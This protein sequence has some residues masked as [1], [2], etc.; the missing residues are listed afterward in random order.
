VTD[1][2]ALIRRLDAAGT[3]SADA[4]EG[5]LAG[6]QVPLVEPDT[7]TFVYRGAA[8][9]VHLQHWG[10]GLPADL[11]FERLAASDL[12]YLVLDVPPG[13][14][15]EYKIEVVDQGGTRVIQDPLNPRTAHNPFGANSVCQAYGY[16]VP[17]WAEPDPDAPQGTLSDVVVTSA[18][19]GRPATTTLYLPAGFDADPARRFPLLV[20]HDGPDYLRYAALKTVLDNLIHS[21]LVPPVVAALS[22][23]GQ[24]L[25]EY[26]DD[27]RHARFLT[28]ELVPKFEADL[29][30]VGDPG[31][32]CLM[33]ASFG[34]VASLAA[35]RRYPGFYG[36]LLL[37]SGSFA[38][39]SNGCSQRRG[40]VWQPVK[41]FVDAYTDAPE[42]VSERVFVSC[43][44]YESLICENRALVPKLQRAGMDVCFV[45]TL[46]GHNW[47]SWRDTLGDALPWLL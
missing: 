42:H 45:E 29:P 38:W 44:V 32:R 47:E 26:A 23:P 1:E 9:A 11:A 2:G 4:L 3:L 25:T 10:V 33:G 24:R 12:W 30:L 5:V 41:E 27:P 14:R 28:E 16:E 35:A 15:I 36:R 46:D 34:A 13:S 43:G 37:Q 22:D 20:V 31:G 19:L 18:T 6:G 21:R 7:C 17:A 40:P 8:T 39:S